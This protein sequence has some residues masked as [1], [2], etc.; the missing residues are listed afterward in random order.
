MLRDRKYLIDDLKSDMIESDFDTFKLT[1][2]DFKPS[3][4]NDTFESMDPDTPRVMVSFDPYEGIDAA[5]LNNNVLK[6]LIEKMN[7]NNISHMILIVPD[8]SVT[9][10]ILKAIEKLRME[11]SHKIEIFEQKE[12]LIN[13][14]EHDL[15]PKHEPLTK[16]MKQELLDRY[17][18]NESQ[19]PKI[20]KS[21]PV[22]RYFGVEPGTVMKITRRSET[23]GRY[24]TYR[25]VC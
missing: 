18:I 13:I 21:D 11:G 15:V 7:S 2:P 16:Q 5:K 10:G 1:Y 12:V 22:V 25:L 9:S 20:L 19:L 23:S 14:T 8:S 17:K 24:V 6:K 4:L 3:D